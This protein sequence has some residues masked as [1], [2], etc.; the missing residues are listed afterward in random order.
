MGVHGLTGFLKRLGIENTDSPTNISHNSSTL[1]IDGNGL[2]FHLFRLA[3]YK[4]RANILSSTTHD[5]AL[6]ALLLLPIFLPL[7]IAH[8]VTTSYLSR[9]TTSHGIHLKIYF[10][11]P[12]Q[13]MKRHVKR[14]RKEQRVDE[15][16]NV[17]QL[18]IHGIL[19]DNNVSKF[20]SLAKKQAKDYEHQMNHNESNYD[21]REAGAEVFFCL[22]FQLV[23]W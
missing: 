21:G 10:D 1:A 13:H 17:R 15:W 4:H 8:E 9:L 12:N 16:E 18:C 5:K 11:G 22:A 19:P 3:Y 20:R 6:R 2:T 7:K 14:S 23:P